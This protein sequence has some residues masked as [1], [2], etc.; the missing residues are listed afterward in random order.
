MTLARVAVGGR[1][2][3]EVVVGPGAL[4]GLAQALPRRAPVAVLTDANVER[5]HA[6]R[7]GRVAE[8]PRL[9]VPAGDGSKSL[10]ML[11]RVLDFL[12]ASGLDR[13]ATLVAFG[14]GMVG[15]LGGLAAALFMRGIECV[16]CP[17]TLLAQV[18]S[19]VGGKTAVNLA[20]GKNLAGVFH[21]PCLV[22]ADTELLATLPEVELC[23]G[24]GE[25]VKTALI[26]GAGLLERLE[27]DV[28]AVRA[29]DPAVL[30][31]LVESCV[32]VKAE[33]VARD[34]EERRGPRALLNLG[35]TFGHGLEQ[36]AGPGV[37]PH[38]VAV[39]VGLVLALEA[40]ARNGLLEQPELVPRV[41]TLLEQLGLPASLGELRARAGR[42]LAAAEVLAGMRHDKKGAAGRPAFVLVRG[43]GRL[44]SGV[45]LESSLLAELLA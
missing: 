13:H 19:S 10:P 30:A 37:I 24:L 18:D 40:S 28:A 11:E 43:E 15:D 4:G 21:P 44:V 14:G 16:Q 2:P 45:V 33:I 3:Y 9:A 6:G 35:H 32:A 20:A 42:R 17:T 29:R 34:E 36:A 12:V 1:R 27:R 26:A 38:G 25:V 8:Q 23:A 39:A 22:L 31:A 41:R 5:L 7:L